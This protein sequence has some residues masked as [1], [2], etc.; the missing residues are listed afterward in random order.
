MIWKTLD[1]L[2]KAVHTPYD[3][4]C[5]S[6]LVQNT[7]KPITT[8]LIKTNLQDKNIPV[9]IRNIRDSLD[10][11]V[12]FGY[13]KSDVLSTPFNYEIKNKDNFEILKNYFKI[14]F[15]SSVLFNSSPYN[16]WNKTLGG[17]QEVVWGKGVKIA[18]MLPFLGVNPF[19]VETL[20]LEEIEL[21]PKSLR[22]KDLTKLFNENDARTQ[23]QITRLLN[24]KFLAEDIDK[25]SKGNYKFQNNPFNYFSEHIPSEFQTTKNVFFDKLKNN[26]LVFDNDSV[27]SVRELCTFTGLNRGQIKH[28]IS[29]TP[30][31]FELIPEKTYAKYYLLTERS[32]TLIK[33]L[34]LPLFSYLKNNTINSVFSRKIALL[35]ND[36]KSYQKEFYEKFI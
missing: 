23:N 9:S 2:I 14:N 31:L 1:V 22:P 13:L 30:E 26:P 6:V 20:N 11:L 29:T 18:Y 24:T 8:G 19:D 21:I 10:K 5:F 3:Y 32:Q 27:T 33:E 28:I 17:N 16:F 25:N 15:V 4:I 34:V 7:D 35:D 36:F 12:E